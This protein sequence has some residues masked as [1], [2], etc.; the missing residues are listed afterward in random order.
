MNLK[1]IAP[2]QDSDFMNGTIKVT[3]LIFCNFFEA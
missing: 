2:V 3:C 1:L